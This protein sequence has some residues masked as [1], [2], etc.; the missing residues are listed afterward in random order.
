MLSLSI[1]TV[2]SCGSQKSFSLTTQVPGLG[3]TLYLDKPLRFREPLPI[4]KLKRP[5]WF[6]RRSRERNRAHEAEC[7]QLAIGNRSGD[8]RCQHA[9]ATNRW[10]GEQVSLLLKRALGTGATVGTAASPSNGDASSRLENTYW[11]LTQLG[12]AKITAASQE[13]AAHLIFYSQTHR[14]RGSGG[15]NRVTGSYQVNGD[16][17]TFS[18]M[19][20]TM[21]ACIAGMDRE[22]AFL[23][24]LGRVSQWK[25]KGQYLDLLDADGNVVAKL[26]A[27]S[28]R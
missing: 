16:Q 28:I 3:R 14:V 10:H 19:A 2:T 26:E 6:T 18:Q 21:M 25:I 1:L 5:F 24:A 17:L 9:S 27:G 20:G 11:K 15:C 12:K 23:L 4:R 22:E 7:Y 13:Q 8:V